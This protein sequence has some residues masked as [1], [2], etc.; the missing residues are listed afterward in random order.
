MQLVNQL[1]LP[2]RLKQ[3][4][5]IRSGKYLFWNDLPP[6]S[7]L[8][9]ARPLSPAKPEWSRHSP[10]KTALIRLR[11]WRSHGGVGR[12]TSI[13]FGSRPTDPGKNFWR[14]LPKLHRFVRIGSTPPDPHACN[15]SPRASVFR[16]DF[17]RTD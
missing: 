10:R 17:F 12:C 1:K 3:V 7:C 4:T 9:T 13:L 6:S 14:H 5:L 15:V 11:N 2:Y 16:T 8:Y